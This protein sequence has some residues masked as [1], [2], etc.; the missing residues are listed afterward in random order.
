MP[1]T[2]FREQ[3][4]TRAGASR[5]R[6][7]ELRDAHA[8]LSPAEQAAE[9]ARIDTVSDRDLAAELAAHVEDLTAGTVKEVLA[10]VGDDPDLAAVALA[11]EQGKGDDARTSLVDA[12]TALIPTEP[13]PDA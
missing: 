2:R 11:R 7:D 1:D 5:T 12:L 8:A 3:R 9:A 13:T 4:W 6:L 10:K